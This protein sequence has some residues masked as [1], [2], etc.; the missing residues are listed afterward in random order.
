MSEKV[1]PSNQPTSENVTADSA[2]DRPPVE[3]LPLSRQILY[4]V[5]QLGWSS[6]TGIMGLQLVYFYLPPQQ[7]TCINTGPECACHGSGD[8]ESIPI[9]VSQNS[10][11]GVFNVITILATVGRLWDAVTDPLIASW[12][13]RMRSPYGRRIPFLAIGAV[14][15]ALA[16]VGTF[17]PPIEHESGWNIVWLGVLQFLFYLFITV[18][19]TPY[20]TLV[21]ELG[22]TAKERLD[23]STWCSVAFALGTILASAAPTIGAAFSDDPLAATR[24]GIATVSAIGCAL[25]LVPVFAID[26]KRFCH[27]QPS[28][29]GVYDA[30]RRCVRNPHFRRYVAT[31]ISYFFANTIIS[32]GMPYYVTVLADQDEQMLLPVM[33]TVVLLSFGFYLPVNKLALKLGKKRIVLY[34]FGGLG[35]TFAYVPIIGL[36][37]SPL[38]QLFVLAAVAA[39]PIAVLGMLPSAIAA[40]IAVH[41]ALRT[42]ASNEGMYFAARTLLAKVGMSAGTLVF[43]SL[44]NFGRDK[45]NDTGIR[46]TGPVSLVVF[47]GAA[48]NFARYRE[49]TVLA[50][51][52]AARASDRGIEHVSLR[53][54]EAEH[55]HESG[56]VAMSARV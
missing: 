3:T 7:C 21:A 6:L 10:F 8:A 24:A 23:L 28:D 41:D 18:Y 54:N 12:S 39:F 29:I 46:L 37:P 26:E 34:A 47:A 20:F 19:C 1:A 49:E 14:P 35:L 27:S 51:I 56:G 2:A 30:L 50:E 42:G 33:T 32:T 38:V 53:D 48:L 9:F 36:P 5:G 31:D 17:Y 25:M 16:C 15:A 55:E 11:G 22:H 4:A 13:D 40:D 45:T 43:A 52:E 44:L